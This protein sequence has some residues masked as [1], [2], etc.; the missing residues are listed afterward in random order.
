MPVQGDPLL[1]KARAQHVDT[2]RDLGQR[3]LAVPLKRRHRLGNEERD[4]DVEAY[5][6]RLALGHGVFGGGVDASA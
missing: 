4:R 1:G 2:M 3:N 6:S 5:V